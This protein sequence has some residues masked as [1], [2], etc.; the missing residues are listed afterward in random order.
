M[1]DPSQVTIPSFKRKKNPDNSTT[2]VPIESLPIPVLL[3]D[4]DSWKIQN[5]NPAAAQITEKSIEELTQLELFSLFSNWNSEFIELISSSE[6]FDQLWKSNS[7]HVELARED[8][9]NHSIYLKLKAVRE[10][11]RQILFFLEPETDLPPETRQIIPR[12]FDVFCEITKVAKSPD[13]ET[14]LKAT[15]EAGSNLTE[16]N[17]LAIYLAQEGEPVFKKVI[18][19]GDSYLL[20]EQLTDIELEGVN[21]TDLWIAKNRPV[22]YL[23]R[24]AR[25]RGFNYL[26]SHMLGEKNATIGLLVIAD[27]KKNPIEYLLETTRVI[28]SGITALVQI[29]SKRMELFTNLSEQ[30]FSNTIFQHITSSISEAVIIIDPD[31]KILELNSSAEIILGYQ[32]REARG[33]FIDSILIG[34]QNFSSYLG[35]TTNISTPSTPENIHLYRRNGD[36]FLATTRIVPVVVDNFCKAIVILIQDLTEQE[37]IRNRAQQYEQRATLGEVTAMFA[38]EM[39][40]MINNIST[41]LQLMNRQ[42]IENEAHRK[43]I[44]QMLEECDRLSSQVTAVLEIAKPK[45]YEMVVLD[46]PQLLNRILD[47]YRARIMRAKVQCEVILPPECPKIEG[48]QYAL[49]EV[50]GNLIS[51]AL[52]AMGD[53]GGRLVLRVQPVN[54][55]EGRTFVQVAVADTAPG[56]PPEFR[57]HIFQPFYT[58]KKNGTGLGLA[59]IKGMVSA[60]RGNIKV[61]FYTPGTVFYVQLPACKEKD[62]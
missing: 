9:K 16:A 61:E 39:R 43:Y 37:E 6:Q 44:G 53:T 52:E 22:T 46:V 20:P 48:N 19:Q 28:G 59:I 55:P 31:H 10:N 11:S 15:L 12:T 8:R 62:K 14:A 50:F 27:Q 38:H 58:T 25:G 57:E 49:E 23:H 56:I 47:R 41:T 35:S 29:Y 21:N 40:N 5:A 34:D 33:Q 7:F 1:S 45:K 36:K 51:N 3:V 26:A 54:T 30:E 17:I 2:H 18:G 24:T 32:T 13:I 60:H 42:V 4:S